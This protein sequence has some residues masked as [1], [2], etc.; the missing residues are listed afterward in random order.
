MKLSIGNMKEYLLIKLL[1]TFSR[2]EWEKLEIFLNSPFVAKSPTAKKL[3]C[4]LKPF[5]PDFTDRELNKENIF[6][7]IYPGEE[8]KD[9]KLRDAFANTLKLTEDFLGYVKFQSDPILIKRH[10]LSAISE[11]KIEKLFTRK[12]DEVEKINKNSRQVDRLYFLNE[13]LVL[14]EKRNYYEEKTAAGKRKKFFLELDEEIENFVLYFIFRML[15]YFLIQFNNQKS[16]KHDP[17]FRLIEEILNF[18]AGNPAEQY[19]SLM[20]LYY[21]VMLNREPDKLDN[22]YKLRDLLE[23]ESDSINIEQR[24]QIYVSL[25]NFTKEKSLKKIPG[26]NIIYF[27]L[28]KYILAKDLYPMTEN[29]FSEQDYISFVGEGLINKDYQWTKDFIDTYKEKLK[30]EVK[31][32]AL[33]YC[34]GI[35]NY[36]IG[37]NDA[38]LE[39]LSKV[40]I[41]DFYY[42]LRVKNHLLRIHFQRQEFENALSLIDAFRHFLS[43]NPEIPDFIRTRFFSYA[44]FMGKIINA[45]L[46]DN[47]AELNS[48]RNELTLTGNVENKSWMIEQIDKILNK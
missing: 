19:P 11:K 29:H 45:V 42:Q 18:L 32:N 10:S 46:H 2:A 33:T 26:F 14:N 44:N 22:F 5:Y 24:R 12:A 43:T 20:A 3:L 35:Y 36:R 15:E 13:Y 7:Q 16:I 21:A 1:M 34:M 31:E 48:L 40:H 28:L 39:L 41:K 25:Y 4:I 27:E 37:N 8:Y 23:I 30:P 17:R 38:A 9:K 6:R 47:F